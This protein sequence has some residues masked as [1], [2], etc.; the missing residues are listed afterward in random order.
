ML[1]CTALD[2]IL[3]PLSPFDP[4][5]NES[6]REAALVTLLL[7]AVAA[8]LYQVR[9]RVQ[10]HL[11]MEWLRAVMAMAPE[12]FELL[13][14]YRWL[15]F[16]I[17]AASYMILPWS[18]PLADP[19]LAGIEEPIGLTH[20]RTYAW[21]AE[22]GLLPP[23]VRIYAS[24]D[25]QLWLMTA[26]FVVWKRDVQRVWEYTAAVAVAGVTSIVML[27][28]FPAEG[29]W[30]WY[31]SAAYADP[32]PAPPYLEV[33]RE[34]REGRLVDLVNPHG[35]LN[36]PS[37]HTVFALLIA[38]TLRG[39]GLVSAAAWTLSL[40]VVVSVVPIGWHYLV[41]LVGG[42]AWTVAAVAAVEWWTRSPARPV[43]PSRTGTDTTR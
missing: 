8:G 15:P 28:A 27:W 11:T 43:S 38:W 37:F 9:P 25:L 32:P 2:L 7:G 4:V 21:F 39:N 16:A 5:Q 19:W 23:L 31:G 42:V 12:V 34:L 36:F 14:F 29:P 22:A 13:M 30:A 18:L 20:P 40:L 3:W 6:L 35:F 26:Y 41:D 24:V 17:T 33:L 1:G 10:P